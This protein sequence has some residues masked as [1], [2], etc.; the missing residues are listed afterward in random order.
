MRSGDETETESE[1]HLEAP[2]AWKTIDRYDHGVGWIAHPGET[3]KRASH[4]LA[5]DDDVWVVDPVD[6]DG[7]DDLLAA[8]GTV[9]GVVLALDRHRRD[10]A[11]VANRHDV[12]VYIPAFFDGVAADLSAPVERIDDELA[13]TAIECRPVTDNRFWQ[14]AMLYDRERGTLLVPEAVGTA[15]YFRTASERLGVHPML[16]LKPPSALRGLEPDRIL[17]GH[18]AGVH[19]DAP[20]ALADALD[21]SL[22]RT[23]ALVGKTVRSLFPF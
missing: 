12:P 23:P 3:M 10:C 7:L 1:T 22:R 2:R 14:E 6:V 17:L 8:F 21:G 20:T 4:L 11:A 13:S 15:S 18:G 5:V 9:R 16:R 19:S